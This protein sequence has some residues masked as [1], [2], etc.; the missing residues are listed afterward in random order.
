MHAT[1]TD[2]KMRH[3][4]SCCRRRSIFFASARAYYFAI[5]ILVVYASPTFTLSHQ[6]APL[7]APAR[8]PTLNLRGGGEPGALSWSSISLQVDGKTI[9]E[10]ISGDARAGV[11]VMC[12]CVCSMSVVWRLSCVF[13]CIASLL[14]AC[15]CNRETSRY[16]GPIGG[17]EDVTSARLGRNARKEARAGKDSTFPPSPRSCMLSL[18]EGCL[19]GTC[20]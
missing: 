6:H 18:G 15:M 5:V 1:N 14:P 10:D 3:V 16:H 19:C 2:A 8:T 4:S 12:I 7:G 17:W 11:S 13:A 20:V 9:L